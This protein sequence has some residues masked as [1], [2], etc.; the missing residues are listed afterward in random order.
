MLAFMGIG[1]QE[2]IIAA[3]L[4]FV[5]V[6][7]PVY[8]AARFLIVAIKRGAP[9]NDPKLRPCPDCGSFVSL[10]AASCPVCGRPLTH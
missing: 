8:I 5:F 3:L 4:V 7:L 1:P 2:L 10:Q 6:L 9:T